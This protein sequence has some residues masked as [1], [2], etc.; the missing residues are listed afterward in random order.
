M[1]VVVITGEYESVKIEK[2]SQD[3]AQ[4]VLTHQGIGR[5]R[6]ARQK[7][8]D[9]D[10]ITKKSVSWLYQLSSVPFSR[11]SCLATSGGRSVNRMTL[12][13]NKKLTPKRRRKGNNYEWDI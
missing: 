2:K 13:L 6:A 1:G 8:C 9:T 7:K 11:A 12:K 10:K 3:R 5:G 4:W